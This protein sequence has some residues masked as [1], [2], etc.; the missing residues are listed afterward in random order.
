[1]TVLDHDVYYLGRDYIARSHRAMQLTKVVSKETYFL[2]L[3]LPTNLDVK[4]V[5]QKALDDKMLILPPE[6]TFRLHSDTLN[7]QNVF[8]N[9]FRLCFA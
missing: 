3:M 9:D 8:R 2:W 1:M 4:P 5:V 7:G 6:S